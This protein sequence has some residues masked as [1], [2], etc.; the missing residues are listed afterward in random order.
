MKLNDT[1]KPMYRTCRAEELE[2]QTA[3]G[4][5]PDRYVMEKTIEYGYT[6]AP[7]SAA[8]ASIPDGDPVPYGMAPQPMLVERAVFILK[9]H[10]R[11][12]IER[13]R[14]LCE[15]WEKKHLAL[16]V[17]HEEVLRN[18]RKSEAAVKRLEDDVASLRESTK[19]FEEQIEKQRKLEAD[20]GKLRRVLGE[21]AVRDALGSERGPD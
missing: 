21:K 15:E 11:P 13:L 19:W 6:L 16:S 20:F 7:T 1:N 10:E 2:A 18:L 12:E 4:W 3:A 17:I 14:S 9:R 5:V 8:Y